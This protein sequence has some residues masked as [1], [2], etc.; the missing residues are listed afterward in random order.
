M[1]RPKTPTPPPS[2][3]E[4]IV[5]TLAEISG[6]F[7]V[8]H[9]QGIQMDAFS[10]RVKSLL[11]DIARDRATAQA[12]QQGPFDVRKGELPPGAEIKQEAVLIWLHDNKEWTT[13][14]ML[15]KST[16]KTEYGFLDT[17][18]YPLWWPLPPIPEQVDAKHAD[19]KARMDAT[20]PERRAALDEVHR[21]SDEL[22]LER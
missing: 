9:S 5:E 16:W 17:T 11:A 2:L 22:G 10:W 18:D 21:L 13:G 19:W 7:A 8:A 14:T 3:D 4:R 20:A 12:R 15:F 1:P 6:Q